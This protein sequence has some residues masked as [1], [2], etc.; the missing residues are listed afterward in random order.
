MATDTDTGLHIYREITILT[1][2]QVG[3]DN[4]TN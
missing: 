3:A 1:M 4:D 2:K